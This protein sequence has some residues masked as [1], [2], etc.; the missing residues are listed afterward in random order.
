MSTEEHSLAETPA[1]LAP[2]VDEALLAEIVR[3][4]T[5]HL[6]NPCIVLFGSH[7]YGQPSARSDL[8]LLVITDTQKGTYTVAGELYG[9]LRPRRVRMDI[10]VLT[11]E[12]YRRRRA[13]FDPFLEEIGSKGRVLYGQLP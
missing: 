5:G 1:V 3:R 4:I 12:M 2:P 10:V 11:P 7:A 6:L 13:G 8:D 9:I